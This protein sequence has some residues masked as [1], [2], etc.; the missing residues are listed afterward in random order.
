MNLARIILVEDEP[1]V[2]RLVS[3]VLTDAGYRV[4]V[5]VSG[6]DARA[7]A[8]REAP[9][10]A[11]VDLGLPD[12]DGLTLVRQL[13]DRHECGIIVLSGRGEAFERIV[14]LEVGA[15]DYMAKPF[16]PRELLARVRSVLR[17]IRPRTPHESL[18][19]G[20]SHGADPAA[21]TS[22]RTVFEFNDWQLDAGARLLAKASGDPVA[23]M[24]GEFDLLL[25]LVQ[26]AGRVLTREQMLDATHG[27]HTPAFDRSVDVAVGRIR[28]K[29]ERDPG[30]PALIKTVRSRGYMFTA[31]VRR[32]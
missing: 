15:D 8:D 9:D 20:G 18:V 19:N 23:L 14:G 12:C 3:R 22:A 10:L 28:R 30:N 32:V 21:Q 13:V 26:S 27:E 11:I 5:A 6:M 16:E 1:D 25:T 7:L 24:S 4:S 29:I 31:A 17:R 2:G